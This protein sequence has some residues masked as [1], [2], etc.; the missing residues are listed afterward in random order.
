[1]T[2]ELYQ[3]RHFMAIVDTGSFTRASV[4]AAV[5]Q[6]ALSASIARLEEELGVKLLHRTPKAITPTSAGR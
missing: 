1:M 6:S 3:L 2:M 5:S 4:R